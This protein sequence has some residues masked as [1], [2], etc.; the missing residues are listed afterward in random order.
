M[1]VWG[2]LILLAG[3]IGCQ[4][5][6]AEET[7]K[8]ESAAK[9]PAANNAEVPRPM[10]LPFKPLAPPTQAEIDAGWIQLFDG[11]TLFGWEADDAGKPDAVNWTVKNGVIT[12]DAGGIGLLMTYVPFAD[13]EFR[14]EYR[15]AKDGNSGVFLRTVPNPTDP[16]VDCYELNFCENHKAFPTGSLVA[17]HKVPQSLLRDNQWIPVHVTVQGPRIQ[18]K[19]GGEKVL[20][21]TDNSEHVRL[22]GR[23]G[24]QKNEGKIEFRHIA[25]KPLGTKS[26]FNGKDLSGWR[27]VPGS[28]S[29]FD[30]DKGAI[31][32]K[33]GLGFLETENTWADF[34]LAGAGDHKNRRLQ[35]RD[36]LSRDAGRR[37]AIHQRLRTAG[38]ERSQS[39]GLQGI[40]RRPHR[41]HFPPGQPPEDRLRM[42]T[43][44]SISRW[45]PPVPG[46][47]RGSMAIRWRPGKTTANRMRIPAE[48]NASKP[49]TSVCKAT[50]TPPT[51]NT[52]ISKSPHTE[53]CHYPAADAARLAEN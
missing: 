52:A 3:I 40:P 37:G 31:H 47:R 28:K 42:I 36:F 26:L 8:T 32:V 5:K 11:K 38:A 1:R 7:T 10:E 41:G 48:A 45:W 12:A 53:N 15:L 17:R 39:E 19:F 43:S 24:L 4:S 33:N 21:F 51:W 22:S 44:G 30:V 46:L 25:L 2:I 13:Y 34:L 29:Q 18:A 9:E 6:T 16:A 27:Q 35:Q 49:G 23:I 14:C 20:D 50:M